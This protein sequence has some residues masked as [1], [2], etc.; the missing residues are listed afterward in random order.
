MKKPLLT[1]GLIF[2]SIFLFAQQ[3][4]TWQQKMPANVSG[5]LNLESTDSVTLVCSFKGFSPGEKENKKIK[6]LSFH[7]DYKVAI[8][9]LPAKLVPAFLE[10]NSID[11]ADFLRTPKE[12]L[13][14]GAF[15]LTLNTINLAHHSFPGI[16]GMNI[17]SSVK[18][19]MLD[20]ADIDWKGRYFSSG[21]VAPTQTSHASIMATILGGGANT[22]PYAKGAAPG[23][24]ITSSA[25]TS[26]MPDADS[27]YKKFDISVQNHSYGVG[28]ENFYGADSRAYDISVINNPALVHVFS[29]GNSG[30][31][32]SPSGIYSGMD[33]FA[34]LTGS[35]KM[36]KNI[37]SIGSVDSFNQIMPLS[38]KGPAYDGRLKP[39]LVA[40]GEDGS[41]GAAAL[42][43][44]TTA[45]LQQ[46]YKETHNN[47][48]P[49]A[50]LIK[51]ILINSANDIGTPGIDYAAGYGS[52]DA[53]AALKTMNQ[54]RF[55][56]TTLVKNET[57]T[58]PITVPANSAQLKITIAWTDSAEAPNAP[59]ALV[60]DVD[61]V[62]IN[63]STGNKWQPWVLSSFPNKDSLQLPAV[64]KKDTLNN[65]EQITIDSPESG[66][67]ILELNA[68]KLVTA[69]QQVAIAWQTDTAGHFVWTYPT[70]SD[71]LEA[72]KKN[73]IRWKT[74]LHE[75]ATIE[76]STD[77][78]NWNL[79]T[80]TVNS[81]QQ[82]F[83]WLAPETVT[84]TRLR[85]SLPSLQ[86]PK[87]SDPF[88]ISEP[89][90]L[91][92][93]FNCADS[94]LLFWNQLPVDQ[95]Q[96]YALGEKYLEPLSLVSDTFKVLRKNTSPA[97]HYAV[98]PVVGDQTG[99]RSYTLN[100]TTQGVECY[101]R[102][103][104]AFLQNNNQ[105][106]LTVSVGILYNIAAINFQ[107]LSATGY[108]TIHTINNP[109]SLD[110]SFIDNNLIQGAN[111]Y[112]IEIKL[113]DGNTIYSAIDQVYYLP[114]NP[115]LVFPNPA[116]ANQP[117][118][119]ATNM[120]G[121]YTIHIYDA[122]GRMIKQLLLDDLL[123]TLPPVYLSTGMYFIQIISGEGKKYHQ[124]LVVY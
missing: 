43:S 113:A 96:V 78:T 11:F 14:T 122:N 38:S 8:I 34:N 123:Q 29:A 97:L 103:F 54:N 111:F 59:K 47:L 95:Y 100:Y 1:F 39:E 119:I 88:V 120:P 105:A 45:L 30:T 116:R 86:Q 73:I 83:Q 61:A 41:S 66:E 23:T 12:E 4:E 37:L 15:D 3:K 56:E 77:N 26:L 70:G 71:V 121:E 33:G 49:P 102:T 112:R 17:K 76:Y 20:S 24:F 110:L 13:T 87:L 25:F 51:A 99:L 91:K 55:I 114:G 74:N 79:I 72:G 92:I 6:I 65:V 118:K 32:A 10:N 108:S 80:S 9:R 7:P 44:G 89:L 101:L 85:M 27:V 115:V 2:F 53:N 124:K 82:F 46:A 40:Y 62:V 5:K 93:G 35:F 58:I 18:E 69:S 21:V 52:L 104:Y 22:S 42:V 36:A 31:S 107:K 109:S 48:L 98:A 106:L 117:I 28:I 94:F 90:Q 57:R 84:T 68:D 60:N 81:S 75:N 50:A 16:T 19:Q 64:R 63:S 67:Y